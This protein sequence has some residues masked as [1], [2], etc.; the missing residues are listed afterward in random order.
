MTRP[1]G[2]LMAY[3]A[4]TLLTEPTRHSLGGLLMIV[5]MGRGGVCGGH[6]TSRK[7]YGGFV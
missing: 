5:K 7:S 6:P 3:R 2:E 1:R 4:D